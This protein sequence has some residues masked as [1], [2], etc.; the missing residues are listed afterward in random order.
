MALTRAAILEADDLEPESIH[1]PEWGGDVYLRVMSVGE[2]LA[3]EKIF[4]RDKQRAVP[5]LLAYTLADEHG[6]P[7]FTT[8]D[9][10][11]LERKNSAVMIRLFQIATRKNALTGEDVE[12]LEKKSP[13]SP[14]LNSHSG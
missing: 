3:F 7:L 5:A 11:L 9:L 1:V 4:E 13:R 10:E 12:A 8:A 2:R 14:A 6:E